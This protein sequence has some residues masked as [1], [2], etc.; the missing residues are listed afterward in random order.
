MRHHLNVI[1]SNYQFDKQDFTDF[2]LKDKRKYGIEDEDG[3]VTTSTLFSDKLIKDY[4]ANKGKQIKIR[5]HIVK[6]FEDFEI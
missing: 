2:A 1:A 4:L 6:K 3:F 5:E